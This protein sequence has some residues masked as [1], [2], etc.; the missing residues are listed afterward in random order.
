MSVTAHNPI[1]PGFFPDPSAIAVGDDFYIVNSTFTYF[2]GL[3]V[4][5]SKDLAHWDQIGN[6]MTRESQLPLKNA[7]VSRGLFAPTI[8][9]NKGTFYVICTNVSGGGNFIVTSDKAEG[10]YS[11]P[12]YLEGADGIDP[13]LFFDDDGKCYYIGTHPNPEGCKYDGDWYIYIQELDIKN[14]KL[15]GEKHNVWNGAMRGVHW[16]EGPHLYKKDGL[17]YILHAE[18]GT[19]PE[20]AVSVARSNEVFGPYEGNFKNPIL[21]HRHLGKH[22]PIQYVGHADM[23]CTPKGD[24]YMV[25]LG[26]RP[27]HEK[28]TLGRETF[29]AR[30]IWEDA[31]PV[32]NPNVGM[33]TMA[34]NIDLDRFENEM[35]SNSEPGVDKNYDFRTITKFGPEVLSLRNPA[36][37]M[38][39][40]VEK[41]G[42]KLKCS[43][44][45]ITSLGD[46]SFLGVRQ[47]CHAFEI[48]CMINTENLCRGAAA[49]LI[50]FQ[51]NMHNIR[52]EVSNWIGY[53]IVAHNG[54]EEKLETCALGNTA[55]TI[56][57]RVL[58][59]K[60]FFFILT[61]KGPIPIA[62][63]IDVSHLS[64]EIAGGFVGCTCGIYAHDY[65]KDR[66][67]D[68]HAGFRNFYYKRFKTQMEEE[69]LE[70]DV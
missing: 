67:I 8:R 54:I 52:F 50:V 10:P 60:A 31:W 20:H 15:V 4:M 22:F 57:I 66:D 24:W 33:L 5:H 1:L 53:I 49:G 28:T 25:M 7:E 55:A 32:V 48:G 47:D 39:E 65:D 56:I 43:K 27:L 58:G 9:Y 35:I 61:E 17:Y 42:L 29:L 45:L 14:F 3:P 30:V 37:D 38:Y 41:K 69:Q 44:D 6:V 34:L 2:P 18:G 46:V 68:I 36:P 26:V 23:F 59:L 70:A 40:L 21:T 11:E 19:G 64:T 13:S 12:H 16:P 51:N 63:N 62:G